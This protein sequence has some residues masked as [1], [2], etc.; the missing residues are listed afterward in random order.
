MNEKGA[1]LIEAVAAMFILAIVIVGILPAFAVQMHSNTR[2]EIRA[3]AVSATQ[4][5]VEALR[6]E[7]PTEMN[8]TGQVSQTYSLCKRDYMVVTH[9]CLKPQF[10]DGTTRHLYI[11]VFLDG[12]KVYDAETVQTAL[13]AP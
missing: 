6:A 13:H 12:R 3:G 9:F 1:S 4:V 10:C 8:E 2:N 7:D 11:E 5:A